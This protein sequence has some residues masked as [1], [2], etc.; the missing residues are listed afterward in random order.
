LTGSKSKA[1]EDSDSDSDSD[2]DINFNSH[3]FRYN[4]EG[5]LVAALGEAAACCHPL[6]SRYMNT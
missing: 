1:S 2:S 6:L 4:P 5:A 3:A